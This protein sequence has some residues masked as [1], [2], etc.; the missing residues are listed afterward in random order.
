MNRILYYILLLIIIGLA[1]GFMFKASFSFPEAIE[2][3][4][5]VTETKKWY[6]ITL[7]ADAN[8]PIEYKDVDPKN[9]SS[10]KDNT[11]VYGE[12]GRLSSM[13]YLYQ[14]GSA[15]PPITMSG[16]TGAV[17]S[18]TQWIV[19]LYDLFT[20]YT[21]FDQSWAYKIEQVTN[22]SFYIGKEKDGRIAIYAIDG[23]I[24]LYFLS[25]WKEMT[26]MLLFPSSYI[27]FDPSRNSELK[28]T[29]LFRTILSLD[30][31]KNELFEFV[32]PRVN[33]GNDNDTFFNY[34]LPV[35]TKYL[36]RALS[37]KF[38][39]Q[40]EQVDLLKD[41]GSDFAY[42]STEDS[43]WLKNPSKKNFF[44][45]LELRQLLS[46]VVKTD[47]GST[48]L[49]RRIATLYESAKDL[50]IDQFSEWTQSAKETIET[51]LLDG[52]F[53]LYGDVGDVG[54]GYQETY[55]SIAKMIG[56]EPTEWKSKLLQNLSDIYSANLFLQSK[57]TTIFAISTIEPTATL[58]RNTLREQWIEDK[59][60]FDIAI[61]AYNIIEKV[62][63]NGIF[64]LEILESKYMYDYL[65]TFFY[66]GS[67]YMNS[68]DDP[69][70]K[71][72]IIQWFATKF[73]ERILT[74]IVN[75][76]YSATMYDEEGLL[77]LKKEY[78][79]GTDVLLSTDIMWYISELYGVIDLVNE[80]IADAFGTVEN[81]T[82]TYR[83][84]REA[85]IRL[86]ALVTILDEND[87]NQNYKA[88]IDM[89]YVSEEVWDYFLPKVAS[90]LSGLVTRK[91][92][93]EVI[94][95]VAPVE[96]DPRL[97]AA[98]LVFPEAD[99]STFTLDS[100]FVRMTAWLT[101]I[102]RLDGSRVETFSTLLFQSEDILTQVTLKYGWRTVEFYLPTGSISVWEYN[103]LL[104]TTL[105]PYIDILES[106]SDIPWSVRI[107]FDRKR[108]DIGS[109]IFNL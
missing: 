80:D 59:D 45:L 96:I 13:M 89:P 34:R 38:H 32:N 24:R 94:P 79:D 72:D 100:G 58:L 12:F 33:N 107:Y 85:T 86:S 82:G 55:E 8:A 87:H 25:G 60:Y 83:N 54:K 47:G 37:R 42:N 52:R 101:P 6:S 109:T 69:E 63:D 99:P 39:A 35:E 64:T 10:L 49:V 51:F 103:K 108:M 93:E 77:Y 21:L 3:G 62:Q 11:I 29:D 65:I 61:Y 23:V 71:T 5:T 40:I 26:N 20:T 92:G 44:M 50:N 57:K 14:S 104:T 56:I 30:P 68:I 53:A 1:S 106:N 28:G 105:A 74:M 97:T 15:F 73:Y 81:D 16:A 67:K 4:T 22:G 36:F 76:L 78:V 48:S 84:I 31:Q 43:G 19:S 66:A 90:D 2:T 46:E 18:D 91:P 75:S 9:L 27:R 17:I 102:T 88:Y 70:R 98:M 7:P 41:Y 95:E